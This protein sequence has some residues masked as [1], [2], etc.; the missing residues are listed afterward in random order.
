MEMEQE[1]GS[2]GGNN[3]E[4]GGN[5][6]SRASLRF[7]GVFTQINGRNGDW[8]ARIY[9]NY[10]P[11]SLGTYEKEEEAAVAYDR[12]AI[13]LH[14]RDARPNFPLENYKP[15]EIDF[16]N[17]CTDEELIGMLKGKTY[18]RK[19]MSFLSL[20]SQIANKA[21]K[22]RERVAYQLLFETELTETDA[23]TMKGLYIP[24][25]HAMAYFTP[26][27]GNGVN[28]GEIHDSERDLGDFTFY[29]KQNCP[30][31]FR[32]SYCSSTRSFVF[33]R[34]W[35]YFVRMKN[36]K[37]GDVIAFYR[38]EVEG[39]GGKRAFF[40]IDTNKKAPEVKLF[41]VNIN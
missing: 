29:D 22:E 19:Y 6:R 37:P 17:S 38:C 13:K 28:L 15:E 16:L 26:L 41:G 9:S 35:S 33:T 2:T 10:K 8:G 14:E 18:D 34:G 25:E 24:N 32:Y 20:R 23:S 11:Y 1:S 5:G 21:K 3:D 30:W 7:R 39:E 36:M 12:A 4:N 40:C 31:T 27:V